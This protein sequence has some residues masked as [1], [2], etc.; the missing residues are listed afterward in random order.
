MFDE[1]ASW[2][3]PQTPDLNS[4]PNFDDE[5]SEAEMPLDGCE[6]RTRKES[7]IS[8]WLSGPNGRLSRFDQSEEELMSSGDSAVYSPRR[9]PRR[10]FTRKEKGKKKVSDSGTDRN[11]LD[12][13]ESDSEGTGDGS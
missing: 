5:V 10:R 1:S 6:I 11:E 2:Y 8:F 9:K 4:N 12:R 3:L 7:P 13:C